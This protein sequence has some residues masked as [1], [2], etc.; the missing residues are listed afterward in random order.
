MRITPSLAQSVTDSEQNLEPALVYEQYADFVWRS[1]QRCGLSSVDLE[2]AF[3]DVFAKV[4]ER[5]ESLREKAG[6][7]ELYLSMAALLDLSG[8]LGEI[9]TRLDQARTP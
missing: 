1:L 8:R 2:D 9:L 5:L 7:P 6:S 3:Q 4:Y